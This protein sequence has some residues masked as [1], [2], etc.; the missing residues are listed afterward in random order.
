[1]RLKSFPFA[2]TIVAGLAGGLML[3]G[4]ANADWAPSRNIELVVG[5]A[6]GSGNEIEARA[7]QK[8]IA[9][10]QLASQPVTVVNK[11]GG[12]MAISWAYI[13]SHQ[14]DAHYL[15]TVALQIITNSLTGVNPIS[16]KDVT[17]LAV[18]GEEPVGVAVLKASPIKTAADLEAKL[19]ADPGSLSIGLASSR[20][21]GVHLSI[22]IALKQAGVDPAKLKI[23]VFP[24]SGEAM[25]ALLGG[26]VDVLA[27]P[28]SAIS[29]QLAA[30]AVTG[31]AV[32]AKDRLPA[33]FQDTP[34]WNELGLNDVF[35]IPYG[36]VGPKGMTADQVA[37]WDGVFG[38]VF[39]S[40]EWQTAATSSGLHAEYL[41][42]S[43]SVDYW[44]NDAD[45]VA[46]IL[47]DLGMTK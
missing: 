8:I 30:D 27:A 5:T 14:G 28:V 4:S 20:G 41:N 45:E 24:S 44:T 9:D 36:I 2:L 22:A 46:P 39:T 17:P 19:K 26:H 34:T 23:V 3:V 18:F 37:Y 6:P 16:Y 25:V 47:K 32:G 38:K 13:N 31:L 21:N 15:A 12:A 35:G 33:P 42:S 40:P 43:Q 7:I 1:M 11:A 29:G 10:K